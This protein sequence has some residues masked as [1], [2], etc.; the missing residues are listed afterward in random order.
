MVKV[1]SESEVAQ[2][3]QILRDTMDCSLSGSSVRG[4]SQARILEQVAIS[5]S[6]ESSYP[7]PLGKTHP[8]A[9]FSRRARV[10]RKT[11]RTL[12]RRESKGQGHSSS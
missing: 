6:R 1:E 7:G 9:N 4:I 11:N 12:I 10:T 5:F 2:S 3:C 8:R